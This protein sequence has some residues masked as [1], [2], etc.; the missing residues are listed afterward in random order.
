MPWYTTSGPKGVPPAGRAKLNAEINAVLKLPEVVQRLDSL[1]VLAIG[2]TPADA[3]R[4]NETE[5][6]KWTA[7]IEAARMQAE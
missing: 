1:G 3:Q 7:V 2:G 5:T 4:R 6:R